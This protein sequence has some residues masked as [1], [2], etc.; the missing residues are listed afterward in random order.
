VTLTGGVLISGFSLRSLRDLCVSAVN[1][2]A[3]YT[4]RGDL[5]YA[6]MAQRIQLRP[7][8]TNDAPGIGL[9]ASGNLILPALP[10]VM[11]SESG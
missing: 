6:E 10:A 3:K 8:P 2:R 4:H 1:N 11:K 9:G 7:V 5:D